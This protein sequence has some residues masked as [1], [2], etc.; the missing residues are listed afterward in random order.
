MA[1]WSLSP[2]LARGYPIPITDDDPNDILEFDSNWFSYIWSGEQLGV[3]LV[4]GVLRGYPHIRYATL[5]PPV[6]PPV[7]TEVNLDR[8]NHF[9][10]INSSLVVNYALRHIQATD[11]LVVAISNSSN[12]VVYSQDTPIDEMGRVN[13]SHE[14]PSVVVQSLEADVYTVSSHIR[15]DTEDTSVISVPFE[16]FP[17]PYGK[18]L[19]LSPTLLKHPISV[20]NNQVGI[21]YT[22]NGNNLKSITNTFTIADNLIAETISASEF[23]EIQSTTPTAGFWSANFSF[24]VTDPDFRL[25]SF[26]FMFN[27][28]NSNTEV[29]YNINGTNVMVI[30]RPT[31]APTTWIEWVSP[32]PRHLPMG[33]NT[34][35]ITN[36][37][38]NFVMFSTTNIPTAPGMNITSAT[39]W[40]MEMVYSISTSG[41][42][43]GETRT[44]ILTIGDNT[45]I[46]IH[47]LVVESEMQ[48]EG[49][50]RHIT[51]TATDLSLK[52]VNTPT[53]ENTYINPNALSTI[54]PQTTIETGWRLNADFLDGEEITIAGEITIGGTDFS[55]EV[56]A[57]DM[58]FTI[59]FHDVVLPAGYHT[60][61]YNLVI[62]HAELGDIAVSGSIDDMLYVE[63]ILPPPQIIS[64][65][66][67]HSGRYIGAEIDISVTTLT[68]DIAN[69]DSIEIILRLN[70]DTVFSHTDTITE[71]MLSHSYTIPAEYFTGLPTGEHIIE[72]KINRQSLERPISHALVYKVIEVPAVDII[73]VTPDV[74]QSPVAS[75]T[76]V[77]TVWR[78]T[79][80]EDT[81]ANLNLINQGKKHVTV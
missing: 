62:S 66:L 36:G 79:M 2:G 49:F 42:E 6:L 58:D 71:G 56:K 12:Q 14:I 57:S 19:S 53:L 59:F 60:F 23:L 76:V 18:A 34:I 43:S 70:G 13:F 28:H 7:I 77:D 54:S 37:F 74:F 68:T 33:A 41:I 63:L 32:E 25:L 39:V 78:A 20:A 8:N 61:Y 4:D 75:N 35:Q 10:G 31:N 81:L 29:R 5:V 24:Q 51:T 80:Q 15:R 1:D 65:E 52:I 27:Q 50:G 38:G 3:K 72:V 73:F 26:K 9:F 67:S 11:V 44:T 22:I 55:S 69:G 17:M 46:G 30:P 48:L 21:E 40:A 16:V 64:A 45:D 47:P